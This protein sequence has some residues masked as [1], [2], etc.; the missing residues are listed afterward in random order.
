MAAMNSP[1]PASKKLTRFTLPF[2]LASALTA[3]ISDY[4][5]DD[6]SS[7]DLAP[8]DNYWAGSET[9]DVTFI[10][11]GDTQIGGGAEDKK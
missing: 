3:C 1:H 9:T 11:F 5:N 6:C 4:G 2:L 8:V 10:A 7:D